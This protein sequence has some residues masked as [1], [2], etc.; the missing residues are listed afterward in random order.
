MEKAGIGQTLDMANGLMRQSYGDADAW[1]ASIGRFE[2]EDKVNPPAPGGIVFTGGAP[3]TFW[4]TLKKDMAP[5]PVINRGFGGAMM[6]D[7]IRYADRIVTPYKPRAVVLSA[8]AN[9][10]A[11]PRAKSAERVARLFGDLVERL[12]K[13]LPDALI[14]YVAITPTPADWKWWPIANEANRLIS[15][16]V[17]ADARLRLIDLN[18]LLLDANKM[19]NRSLYGSDGLLN[20]RGYELW[21][22][23]L[24]PALEMEP[25]LA[26]AEG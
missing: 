24:K 20:D 13:S 2:A 19:P 5:L 9:D 10:I 14:F 23:R 18:D 17:A 11:G 21:A 25:P 15:E 26:A 6:N 12:H 16:I 4:T 22:S 7:V 1:R 8:G 3:F